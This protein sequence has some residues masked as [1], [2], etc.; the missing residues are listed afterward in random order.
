MFDFL[1]KM[2]AN[3]KKSSRDQANERLVFV[4]KHDRL[5]MPQEEMETLKDEL[6]AVIARHF[7]IEGNPEV[8]LINEGRNRALGI[9]IP[10]KGR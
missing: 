4:L 5:E 9:S 6:V 10:I 7:I 3:D 8:T 1:K 2:L